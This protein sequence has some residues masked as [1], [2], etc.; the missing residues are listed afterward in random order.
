MLWSWHL[1][2]FSPFSRHAGKGW[3]TAV[4]KRNASLIPLL[5]CLHVTGGDRKGEA[6]TDFHRVGLFL[7]LCF[8]FVNGS[9]ADV[10]GESGSRRP[11]RVG[12]F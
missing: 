11:H 2:D 7:L 3:G 6:A 4:R 5:L 9:R 8:S 12:L 10:T 1:W